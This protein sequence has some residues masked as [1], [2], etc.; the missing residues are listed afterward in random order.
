MLVTW[1]GEHEREILT[2]S[3]V[4]TR[5]RRR[6]IV[7]QRRVVIVAIITIR[8]VKEFSAVAGVYGIRARIDR[9]VFGASTSPPAPA[10]KDG[11]AATAKSTP[12]AVGRLTIYPT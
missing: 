4:G 8:A 1:V 10:S 9:I 5:R 7:Q 3:R 11:V 12:I 2:A 6:A